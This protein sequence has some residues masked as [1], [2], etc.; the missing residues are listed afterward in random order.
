MSNFSQLK[1]F[2]D[3]RQQELFDIATLTGNPVLTMRVESEHGSLSQHYVESW[4]PEANQ[5]FRE[6]REMDCNADRHYIRNIGNICVYDAN[7]VKQSLWNAENDLT[8]APAV[9]Y[10]NMRKAF[11][12]DITGVFALDIS[13]VG[14]LPNVD[15]YDLNIMWDHFYLE[16]PA[17]Y[18]MEGGVAAYKGSVET[19]RAVLERNHTELSIEHARTILELIDATDETQLY[20]GEQ[21]RSGLIG[22]IQFLETELT[23]DFLWREAVKMRGKANFRNNPVGQLLVNLSEGMEDTVALKKYYDMVDPT[24]FN[25][26]QT[27]LTPAMKKRA[28]EAIKELGYEES[29][30]RRPA[31]ATDIN[32]NDVLFSAAV[33]NDAGDILDMLVP[34]TTTEVDG[35]A[36]DI[37]IEDFIAQVLPKITSMEAYFDNDLKPNA[38]TLVAPKFP[39]APVITQWDNGFSWAYAGG[40]TDSGM[41]EKV[42]KA[43]GKTEGALRISLGWHNADDLDL[44]LRQVGRSVLYHGTRRWKGGTLDV[45]MNAGSRMN[46][47]DPVENIIFQSLDQLRGTTFEVSVRQYSCRTRN[48]PGFYL[49]VETSEG[50]RTYKHEGVVS[51]HN[52]VLSISVDNK[53]NISFTDVYQC[54]NAPTEVQG[55]KTK[56]Y[57]N[58]SLMMLSPNHWGDNTKGNKHY[59]FILDDME[60]KEP[61]RGIFN[62]FLCDELK[63]HRKTMQHL[64]HAL[65]SQPSPD[66]LSGLGFSSTKRET[67]NVRVRGEINRS[68]NIKF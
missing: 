39:D 5:V 22:L 58:V 66:Q 29:I 52:H 47:V 15:N 43:G 12:T 26:S 37:G 45:D 64:G 65:R 17:E 8:G 56:S 62:E 63:P 60:N 46:S 49:E 44:H 19:A 30:H 41:K 32:V 54:D 67:L 7:G 25:H 1:T 31:V 3:K 42:K 55:V 59:F 18:V 28:A 51:G 57:Q 20:R 50:V 61:V 6:R 68:Y 23:E 2:L 9:L 38:M 21:Y 14:S 40:I 11:T 48:N 27:L 36:T 10:A 13:K 16:V 4:P 33:T 24:K 35:N 34:D 53:G